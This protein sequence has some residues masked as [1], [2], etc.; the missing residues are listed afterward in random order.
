MKA[1]CYVVGICGGTCSGKTTLARKLYEDLNR[2]PIYISQDSYYKDQ[3]NKSADEL[4]NHNFDHPESLDLDLL[5]AHLIRLKE[6]SEIQSPNYCFKTHERL[7]DVQ[8]IQPANVVIVEGT[9][10][11]SHSDLM[12]LFNLRVFVDVAADV[13]LVRRINR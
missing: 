7:E 9:L 6:A 13:R 5:Y 11:F 3:S 1:D 4:K 2:V 12:D 10:I 8:V